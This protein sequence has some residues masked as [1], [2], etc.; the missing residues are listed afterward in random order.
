MSQLDQIINNKIPVGQIVSARFGYNG[1]QREVDNIS[2][3]SDTD[4]IVGFEMRKS[5]QF[6]YGI[7]RFQVGRIEGE[8]VLIDP[9]ARSGPKVGRP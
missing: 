6:S 7:K 5:G 9:P 8:F 2:Y 1:K 4:C 3:E